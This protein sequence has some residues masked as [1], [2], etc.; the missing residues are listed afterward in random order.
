MQYAALFLSRFEGNALQVQQRFSGANAGADSDGNAN[1]PAP[2]NVQLGGILTARDHVWQMAG[3]VT[4]LPPVEAG[5]IRV[6]ST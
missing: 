1:N 3:C 4:E 2:Q 5:E 6:S